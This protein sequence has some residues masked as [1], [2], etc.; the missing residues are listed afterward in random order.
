MTDPESIY[1]VTQIEP[2]DA[3]SGFACGK[4]PLDD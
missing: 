4:P 2:E 1:L 3:A